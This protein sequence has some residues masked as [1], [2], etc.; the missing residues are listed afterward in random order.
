MTPFSCAAS[1]ASAICRAIGSASSSGIGPARDPLRQVV[2]F[3]QLH[4]ERADAIRFFETVDGGDVRMIQRGEQLRFALK[5]ASRSGSLRERVGQNLERDVAL[6]SR[7][8][9]AIHL[10]HAARAERR[11]DFVRAESSAGIERHSQADYSR[12]AEPFQHHR[13]TM[14][15]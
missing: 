4:H 3:D 8:A 14:I 5:R 11:N 10:A 1:R 7:V 9:G 12:E 6:Q 13:A 15:V 2:A